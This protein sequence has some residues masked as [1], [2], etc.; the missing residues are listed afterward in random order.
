MFALLRNLKHAGHKKK[1]KKSG[2]LPEK[3]T[4]IQH[5]IIIIDDVI[6]R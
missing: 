5:P 6:T 2:M 1:K 4:L 3:R